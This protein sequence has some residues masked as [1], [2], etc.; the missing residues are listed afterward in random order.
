MRCQQA[1][2]RQ[3]WKLLALMSIPSIVIFNTFIYT[4]LKSVTTTNTVLLNALIPV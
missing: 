2:I 1:L 3:H 4:A